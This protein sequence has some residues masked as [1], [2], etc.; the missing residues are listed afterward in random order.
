MHHLFYLYLIPSPFGNSLKKK[1]I[2]LIIL[3]QNVSIIKQINNTKIS[4]MSN[5]SA[6]RL[7]D[8]SH[9]IIRHPVHLLF[10]RDIVFL[11]Q[12]CFWVFYVRIRYSY[13]Y[14]C[15]RH[16]IWEIIPF[17]NFS[18]AN[19]EYYLPTIILIWLT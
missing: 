4:M 9:C 16:I 18:S 13:Y 3:L 7:I 8:C 12:D 17:W 5:D 11:L 1:E 2:I 10:I 14:H 19:C 6:Y 15:S